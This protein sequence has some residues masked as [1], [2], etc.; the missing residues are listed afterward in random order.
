MLS[1]KDEVALH[2]AK[3]LS[4]P[5]YRL[6]DKVNEFE[7]MFDDMLFKKGTRSYELTLEKTTGEDG[8]ECVRATS[9]CEEL[10]YFSIEDFNYE[11]AELEGCDGYYDRQNETLVV[12]LNELENDSTVLHE[13]IHLYESFINDLSWSYHDMLIWALYQDLR[14]KIPALDEIVNHHS[15]QLTQANLESA[16]GNHDLLFLLKSFDLD[17]RMD[18]PLGTVFAYGRQDLFKGYSYKKAE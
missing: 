3:Y 13:M 1:P 8:E 2:E 10:E 16:G 12:S 17:I 14:E 18:Y 6:Y 5:D 7:E 4:T 11:A 9:P 15:H